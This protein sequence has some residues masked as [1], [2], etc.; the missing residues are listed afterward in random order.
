MRRTKRKP[1]GPGSILSENITEL[2][3]MEYRQNGTIRIK[4]TAADGCDYRRWEWGWH[5]CI[6]FGEVLGARD[7]YK[8]DEDFD[9]PAASRL[10]QTWYGVIAV[11][12]RPN[13]YVITCRNYAQKRELIREFDLYGYR[14]VSSNAKTLT[15][16]KPKKQF[17]A[18]S[19]Y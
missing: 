17:V 10:L 19:S 15:V 18:Y 2:E 6:N 13:C 14:T 5:D 16:Y 3:K 8:V 1:R 11:D 9:P 7:I 4:E 12:N